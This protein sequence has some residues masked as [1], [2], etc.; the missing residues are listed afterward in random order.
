MVFPEFPSLSFPLSYMSFPRRR[1]SIIIYN[2]F[3]KKEGLYK[4]FVVLIFSYR[5]IKKDY[6]LDIYQY[7]KTKNCFN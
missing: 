1:E 3:L 2:I 7:N 5:K 4:P 6:P